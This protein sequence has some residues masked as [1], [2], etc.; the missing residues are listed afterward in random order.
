MGPIEEPEDRLQPWEVLCT[1]VV[2]LCFAA[3]LGLWAYFTFCT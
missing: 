3:P 1:V 2:V